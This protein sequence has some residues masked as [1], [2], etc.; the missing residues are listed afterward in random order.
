MADMLYSS[1]Y[2][3]LYAAEGEGGWQGT[4]EIEGQECDHVVHRTELVDWELWVST[5][6]QPLPCRLLITYNEEPGPPRTLITFDNWDVAPELSQDRFLPR[7]PEGYDRIAV[8]ARA[9]GD[10]ETGP[11][12][13]SGQTETTTQP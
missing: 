8:I 5:G 12:D 13:T 3:A 2:D 1:P 10:E 7:I 4:D 6:D 11:A 9:S